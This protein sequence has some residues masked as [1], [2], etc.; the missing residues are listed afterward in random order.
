MREPLLIDWE[1]IHLKSFRPFKTERDEEAM[2][3]IADFVKSDEER[4]NMRSFE[5]KLIGKAYGYKHPYI[6]YEPG[7]P[8]E[9][10]ILQEVERAPDDKNELIAITKS[11]SRYAFF[12]NN[13]IER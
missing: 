3:A 10:S 1:I 13:Y 4:I 11:G 9:T 7:E 12:A 6:D 8:I 2:K 5:C